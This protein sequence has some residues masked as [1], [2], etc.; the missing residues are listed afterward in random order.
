MNISEK[1]DEALDMV[2]ILYIDETYMTITRKKYGKGYAYY[3]SS[4]NLI[5]SR[6]EKDRLNAIAVPPTYI[7]VL[8]C[9]TGNGHILATGH[10]ASGKKQYFYHET[11]SKLQQAKKFNTLL[12]FGKAIPA[13]RR[14]IDKKLRNSTELDKQTVLSLMARILDKTGMR[15]GNETSAKQRDT[16]GLTTL[17]KTHVNVDESN[18]HFTYRGKG[19]MDLDKVF[20]NEK[21]AN[22]I[23]QCAEI[24]GQRLFEYIDDNGQDR[25]ID[26]SD[27]NDFIHDIMDN[28]FSAK[29]F[30]TWRFSCY[31]MAELMKCANADT[32]SSLKSI[33]ETVSE[34][35]GNTPSILQSSYIHPGLIQIAKSNDWNRISD[36]TPIDTTKLLH[37]EKMF[38]P[39]LETEHA[40][41]AV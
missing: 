9:H 25:K 2:D 29:D 23:E 26:S 30:R 24:P 20:A 27:M 38:I 13:F 36:L 34:K 6:Q 40:Q 7:N 12:K 39:Y 1:P 15:V 22:L 11:W 5:E 14:A 19:G 21:V 32:Q 41:K 31:F 4:R 28:R 16:Y 17:K 35:S 8:Y 33:L 10:D 37:E 18:I 3:D